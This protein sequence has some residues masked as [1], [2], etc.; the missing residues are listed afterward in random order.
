MTKFIV[1]TSSARMKSS[2][3]SKRANWGKQFRRVALLE[4]AADR[5]DVS[6]IS[7]RAKGLVKI[8]W[9]EEEVQS[10]SKSGE[11]QAYRDLVAKYQAEADRRNK[12]AQ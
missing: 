10:H 11:L 1:K 5:E 4:I 6:Q 12:A 7:E 3:M 9:L 8:H 2:Y